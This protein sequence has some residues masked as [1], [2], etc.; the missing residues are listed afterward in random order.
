[1]PPVR[2]LAGPLQLPYHSLTRQG[3]NSKQSKQSV[4]EEVVEVISAG[5]VKWM[6]MSSIRWRPHYLNTRRVLYLP[7]LL[8]YIIFTAAARG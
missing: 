5:E 8:Y 1:M 6:I 7:F 4:H 3:V 2:S